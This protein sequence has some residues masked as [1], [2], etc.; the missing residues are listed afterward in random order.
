MNMTLWKKLASG[1]LEYG[2]TYDHLH[3]YFCFVK[4]ETMDEMMK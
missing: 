3:L 4:P 2:R 1:I